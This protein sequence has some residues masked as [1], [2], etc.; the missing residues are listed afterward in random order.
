MPTYRD[1]LELYY[2]SLN[3]EKYL[4]GTVSDILTKW[5]GKYF[6]IFDR[7]PKT[8]HSK[9]KS[10]EKDFLKYQKR[11]NA[12]CSTSVL[13]EFES[14]FKKVFAFEKRKSVTSAESCCDNLGVT[15]VRDE[16]ALH[17]NQHMII[18]GLPLCQLA[19]CIVISNRF[20][21]DFY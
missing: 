19:S 9:F 12:R 16:T 4:P 10:I 6:G 11:Y 15:G 21:T 20:I 18:T 17:Q 3:F 2:S 7:T 14:F 8:V 5:I 13:L 1:A